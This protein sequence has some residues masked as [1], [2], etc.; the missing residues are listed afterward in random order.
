MLWMLARNATE[1]DGVARQDCGIKRL[2]S[3][4]NHIVGLA[5]I[6]RKHT[7][8]QHVLQ[9]AEQLVARKILVDQNKQPG[10]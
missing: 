6:W 3:R 1:V 10:Q 7:A 8:G 2:G 5:P 4:P 9:A